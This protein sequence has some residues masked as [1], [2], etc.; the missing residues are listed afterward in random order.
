MLNK[1]RGKPRGMNLNKH[2]HNIYISKFK[3]K[4][5]SRPTKYEKMENMIKAVIAAAS[6]KFQRHVNC[7]FH[8]FVDSGDQL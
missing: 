7:F 6:I 8:M 4:D 2:D 1:P 3:V 5:G